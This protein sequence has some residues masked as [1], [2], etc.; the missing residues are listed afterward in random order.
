MAGLLALPGCALVKLRSETAAYYTSTVVAGRVRAPEGTPLV[1]AARSRADGSFAH[2][3]MLHGPGGYELIVPAGDYDV[4]AFADLDRNGAYDAGEPAARFEGPGGVRASGVGTVVGVDLALGAEPPPELP[5]GTRF[6]PKPDTQAGAI[7]ALDAPGFSRE[8]ARRGYWAP[9]EAFREAGGNVFFLEPYDPARVPVLFVH[10]AAG[11][12]ADW[13]PLVARLER[14]RYQAWVFQYP[15]GAS[16]EAMAHLLYWKVLNLQARHGFAQM[17]VVAHSMGGLVVRRFLADHGERFPFVRAFVTIS[18]PFD[19]EALAALGVR[20]SPAVIPSWRD[21]QPDGAFL[22]ELFAR[23]LPSG[24]QHYLFYGHRGGAGLARAANDGAVTLASQLRPDAQGE[25]RAISGFDEDHSGILASPRVAARLAEILD[26]ESSRPPAP[27]GHV[28]VRPSFDEVPAVPMQAVLVL[29]PV[30]GGER[31]YLSHEPA[32]RDLGPVPPGEYEA[33]LVAD[34]F[35]ASPAQVRV[36]IAPGSVAEARF[37]LSPEGMLSG[38][39]RA[40][41][42]AID[43]P[44]GSVARPGEGLQGATLVLAGA[45]ERRALVAGN[46][47]LAECLD[48]HLSGG[49]CVAN[50]LFWFANLRPGDYVLTVNAAGFRTHVSRHVVVPGRRA[51]MAPLD[52]EPAR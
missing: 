52:L 46:A 50:G 40:R 14:R 51:A 43:H 11:T 22:R 16:L 36:S 19:G 7:V 25:A 3:V 1:V 20:Q 15:S 35:R 45:G 33:R 34:G 42:P 44:A 17:H 18:T 49:D 12:A 24:V 41:P 32:G 8:E 6:A 13:A 4:V 30:S 37:R 5:R 48:R 31:L 10:G 27:S 39:V 2:H 28:R 38:F 47:T 29:D 23:P 26:R 21:M 9:M